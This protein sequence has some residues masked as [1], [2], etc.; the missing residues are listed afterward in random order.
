MDD[1]RLIRLVALKAQEAQSKVRL[2][3]DFECGSKRLGGQVK[4]LRS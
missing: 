4:W 2:W 3:G 1:K